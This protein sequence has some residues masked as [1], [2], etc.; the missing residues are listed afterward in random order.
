MDTINNIED[1]V[2]ILD[3]N[4]EWLEAVRTRL[5]TRELLELPQVVAGLTQRVEDLAQRMDQLAQRVEDL[6]QRM[7]Q[8]VQRQDRMQ[9]DLGWLKGR[10]IYEIARDDAALIADD[11]GFVLERTLVRL[12]LRR[13]TEGQDLSDLPRGEVQSFHRAD[14]VMQVADNAGN[15]HYIAVEA[16]FTV[17]GRDS[18]RALRNA[19]LLTRFTG[20]PSVAAVAGVRYDR[21]LRDQIGSDQLYWYEIPSEDP[22]A[23]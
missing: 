23:E 8:L 19:E 16:S 10:I 9:D 13:L 15:S 17:N 14:L 21:R 12:D 3:E 11:M 22:E 4:P 2:R 6:A 18:H 1:L 5:L 20:L 7:D